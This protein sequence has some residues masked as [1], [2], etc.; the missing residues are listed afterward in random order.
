MSLQQIGDTLQ[1]LA[2]ID[3]AI[4][5]GQSKAQVEIERLVLKLTAGSDGC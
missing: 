4:K 3:Y 1:Q 2:Q 5:T